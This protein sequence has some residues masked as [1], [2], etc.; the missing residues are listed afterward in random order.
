MD[1]DSKEVSLLSSLIFALGEIRK[2]KKI[3]GKFHH[4]T[5]V[6]EPKVDT[7]LLITVVANSHLSELFLR[8]L[9]SSRAMLVTAEKY[10]R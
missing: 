9:G 6:L 5:A 2:L 4:F 8:L 10:D 1:L 7:Q 3:K